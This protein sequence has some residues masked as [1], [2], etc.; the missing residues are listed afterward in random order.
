[1]QS[2][3]LAVHAGLLLPPQVIQPFGLRFIRDDLHVMAY[4]DGHPEYEAVEAMIRARGEDEPLIRAI[5]TRHDQ[6]QIDHIN[7]EGL[8]EDLQGAAREV[9]F[10]AIDL[11]REM[12]DGRPRACLEFDA[13]SGE[14]VV[15]DVV[16]AAAP[17]P[18]RGGLTDPGGHGAGSSLTAMWRG[19][20]TLPGP[21]TCVRLDGERYAV[22]ERMRAGAF[23]G[24]K[25]AYTETHLMGVVRA[26]TLEMKLLDEPDALAPGGEWVFG[27][28]HGKAHYQI[29]TAAADGALHI[30][31]TDGPKEC[32][33]GRMVGG[34]LSVAQIRTGDGEDGA[35][36]MAI[37]V[38]DD[39]RFTL[40]LEGGA[41][42]VTGQAETADFKDHSVVRLT[43][44]AP[45][46]AAD[47]PVRVGCWRDGRHF[48]F[49]SKVGAPH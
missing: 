19:A 22:P 33:S 39:G 9:C 8:V 32:V 34:R 21:D 27:C 13:I 43:P 28:E 29:D 25:G 41:P 45:G 1:M 7:D 6:S 16:A 40:C 2:T 4:F 26:V 35:H 49:V 14:R 37:T 47:R 31:R 38:G 44:D 17:D 18:A 46:W 30:V 20:S 36:G 42:L 24:M 23:V 15:L 3:P 11:R 10:R 5:L 48:T 12:M